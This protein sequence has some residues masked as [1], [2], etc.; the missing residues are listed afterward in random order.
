MKT[1]TTRYG[2]KLTFDDQRWN[3][4]KGNYACKIVGEREDDYLLQDVN[5]LL[6]WIPRATIRD[7]KYEIIGDEVTI[8]E[9]VYAKWITDP[10]EVQSKKRF[11]ALS[12]AHR[13]L[14]FSNRQ[15]VLSCGDYYSLS[16]YSLQS[17]AL[18]MGGFRYSLG[19]LFE[20]IEEKAPGVYF[21]DFAGHK[22]LYLVALWGSP[23]NGLRN[24]IFWSDE[25]QQFPKINPFGQDLPE[26]FL[27]TY[28]AFRKAIDQRSPQLSYSREALAHL[29]G[30]LGV[31]VE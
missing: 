23:L 7:N 22:E 6:T 16:P 11:Q 9:G 12:Y 4:Q 19:A 14:L 28:L 1:M 31:K 13:E 5:N 27:K 20:A 24:F 15:L 17:E 26:G 25:Q 21:E 18:F 3:L 30:E 8:S 29:L 2:R 10:I